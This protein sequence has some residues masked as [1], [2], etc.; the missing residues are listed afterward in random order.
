MSF[1]KEK[2]ERKRKEIEKKKRNE[3][4]DWNVYFAFGILVFV[5]DIE[6]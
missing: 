1:I 3:I 5:R 2:E 6:F 4:T